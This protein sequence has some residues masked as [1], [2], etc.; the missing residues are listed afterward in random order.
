MDA[1]EDSIMANNKILVAYW[2]TFAGILEL[3]R[4]SS[5]GEQEL[6]WTKTMCGGSRQ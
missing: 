1:S 5:L 4:L 6:A 3:Y 2:I